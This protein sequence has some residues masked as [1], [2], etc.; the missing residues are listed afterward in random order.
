[1]GIIVKNP[2]LLYMQIKQVVKPAVQVISLLQEAT[3]VGEE[4][5]LPV[6]EKAAN[7][8]SRILLD[9]EVEASLVAASIYK[10]VQFSWAIKEIN[11]ERLRADSK[12]LF[13]RSALGQMVF[14]RNGFPKRSATAIEASGVLKLS[15]QQVDNMRKAGELRSRN[16]QI[17]RSSLYTIWKARMRIKEAIRD[18]KFEEG[19]NQ[20]NEAREMELLKDFE[21]GFSPQGNADSLG[22]N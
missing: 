17:L 12:A 2:G 8:W 5:L 14:Y 1:M 3:F 19:L 20:A 9:D 7:R 13:W 18:Q 4:D 10:L 6:I 15:R 22:A 11:G 21:T 16:K